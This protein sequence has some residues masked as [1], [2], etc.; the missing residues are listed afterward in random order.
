M[1]TMLSLAFMVFGL[2]FFVYVTRIVTRDHR[3]AYER[4]LM[5]AREFG[6]KGT[7]EVDKQ[8]H[9]PLHKKK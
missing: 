8:N 7:S 3:E 5:E 1:E 2:A 6:F 4:R 9:Q